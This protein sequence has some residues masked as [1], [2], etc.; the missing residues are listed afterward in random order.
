MFMKK[1]IILLI[2]VTIFLIPINIWATTIDTSSNW[3]GGGVSGFGEGATEIFGQTFT[4]PEIDTILDSFTFWLADVVNSTY[5]PDYVDFSAYVMAWE[6]NVDYKRMHAVGDVL[7]QSD[8]QSTTNNNGK[9]LGWEEFA[10]QTD[11][12][13]L[14]SG[15]QY[16]IFLSSLEFNDGEKGYAKM[17]IV[18]NNL[19]QDYF[20][21]KQ[22]GEFT[23]TGWTRFQ[24]GDDAA[25]IISF[26]SPITQVPEPSTLILFGFSILSLVGISIK[27]LTGLLKI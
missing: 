24:D 25:V 9:G 11:G 14:D 20:V 7:W 12:I 10:F 2:I 6:H 27:N 13:K 16:I 1:K 17:G 23:S 26:S 22:G 18:P 3:I 21:A 8:Q 5:S 19:D 15:K 4:V